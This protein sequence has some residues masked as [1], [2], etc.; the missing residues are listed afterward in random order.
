MVECLGPVVSQR[1]LGAMARGTR[2]NVNKIMKTWEKAGLIAQ[3][4]RHILILDRDAL[5]DIA[6]GA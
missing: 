1:D 4:D 6:R 3:E 5:D 2:E